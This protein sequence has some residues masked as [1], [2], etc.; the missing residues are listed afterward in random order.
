MYLIP[1]T[2]FPEIDGVIIHIHC[3]TG[4]DGVVIHNQYS[5]ALHLFYLVTF[6]SVIHLFIA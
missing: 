6:D 1:Q 4:I 3:A 2:G 5:K